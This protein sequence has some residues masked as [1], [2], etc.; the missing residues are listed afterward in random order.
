[1]TIEW[2]LIFVGGL[3]SAGHCLGMCGGFV[4]A[5]GASAPGLAA[6]ARRQLVYATGRVSVYMLAGAVVGYSGARLGGLQALVNTQAIFCIA[7]GMVLIGQGLITAGVL[8]WFTSGIAVCPGASTFA[9]LLRAP[10][11]RSVFVAGACNGLLPCALVYAYLA[12]AAATGDMLHA[13]AV[14]ALFGL[15]TVFPLLL[16]GLTGSVLSIPWRRKVLRIAAW[17]IV[18][19]GAL[20]LARGIQYLQHST[21]DACPFCR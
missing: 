16:A 14:M 7:A 1:M 21:G 10:R 3:T 20:T 17:C 13:T 5:L 18:L 19:T 9:A 6:N 8:P 12:L 2:L 15:G 11:L 4:L